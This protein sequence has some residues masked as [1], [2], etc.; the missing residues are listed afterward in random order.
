M[1]VLDATAMR[2]GLSIDGSNEYHT[3]PS[4]VGELKRG[5]VARDL[6]ML[7]GLHITISE[8]KEEFLSM[9]KSAAEKT[10][11]ISRLSETDV[12]VLALALELGATIVSDDYSIQN[13]SRTLNINYGG[14]VE[15]GIKEVYEWTYRCTGCGRYFDEK[16]DSCQICGSALKVVR[17]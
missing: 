9:I 16:K 1:F 2:S 12:D 7:E 13:V 8:P 15:R 6:E 17:K 14:G 5:K 3:T 11:D 4:V 10:G